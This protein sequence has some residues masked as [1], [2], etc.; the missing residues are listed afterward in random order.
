[1]KETSCDGKQTGNKHPLE[2]HYF[3]R[4]YGFP[5]LLYDLM[6]DPETRFAGGRVGLTPNANISLY[7][8]PQKFRHVWP[9]FLKFDV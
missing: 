5:L 3:G 6:F 7:V 2:R 1:V 9:D 8:G 4:F